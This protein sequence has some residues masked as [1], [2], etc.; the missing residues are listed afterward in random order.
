MLGFD[1]RIAKTGNVFQGGFE[2]Y[3]QVKSVP[4]MQGSKPP[5]TLERKQQSAEYLHVKN[6][7]K[8]G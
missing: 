7:E 6:K 4:N 1:A 8:L 2:T 3:V 5:K